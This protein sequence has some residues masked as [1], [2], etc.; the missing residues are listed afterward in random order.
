LK[1]KLNSYFPS[2]TLKQYYEDNRDEIIEYQKQHYQDNRD[3][4]KEKRKEKVNCDN[5]GSIVRKSDIA[6]HKKSKKC[7]EAKK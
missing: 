3:K 2:R 4:I 5:C 1:T 6:K 7:M